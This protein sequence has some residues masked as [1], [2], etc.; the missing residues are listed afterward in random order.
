MI[1]G[2]ETVETDDMVAGTEP[3]LITWFKGRAERRCRKLNSANI[4]PTFRY[5][6][7]GWHGKFAV[8]AMQNV[9][10]PIK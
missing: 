2:Y 4:F 6:V 7:V 5:K 9:A 10:R 8:V 3:D 1:E